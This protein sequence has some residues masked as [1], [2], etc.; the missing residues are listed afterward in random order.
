[1]KNLKKIWLW[2][3]IL[4]KRLYKKPVFLVLLA[5]IPLLTWGYSVAAAQESGMITVLLAQEGKDPL[6]DQIFA[7]LQN[8]SQFLRFDICRSEAQARELLE[9]GKGDAAWIFPEDLDGKLDAFARR[10]VKSNAFIKVLQRQENVAQMLTR[11]KL[12]GSVYEELAKR[13]YLQYIR[14]ETPILGGFSDEKLLEY[15]ENAYLS[16]QLFTYVSPDGTA[17]RETTHYLLAPLRGLLAVVGLLCAMATA[18]YHIRDEKQ[19][20]FA[21]V[22]QSRCWIPELAGQVLCAGHINLV[23]LICLWICGLTGSF[24]SEAAVLVL[25]SLCTGVFAM[26]LRRVFRSVRILGTLLP[27]L[28]VASLVICPVFFDFG[29]MRK[30]QMLLPPTYFIN[31][32]RNPMYLLYML[33]YTGLCAGVC[34]LFD[35]AIRLKRQRSCAKFS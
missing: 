25:Y 23:C 1:M 14:E 7:E 5:L 12:S 26:M 22:R 30:F 31:S 27:L 19:G 6:V 13:V 20:T 15:F 21:W 16:E 33:A 4:C 34:L 18:M 35:G 32:G 24:L 17:D 29:F 10:P 3:R 8:S 28:T 11:E 2:F 9:H